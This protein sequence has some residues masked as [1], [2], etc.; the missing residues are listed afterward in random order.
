MD[1]TRLNYTSKWSF[2]QTNKRKIEFLFIKIVFICHISLASHI[3]PVSFPKTCRIE[4]RK[5][6]HFTFGF[7]D[8]ATLSILIYR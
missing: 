1:P 8:K 2:P 6:P 5:Y 4:I 7:R 3:S